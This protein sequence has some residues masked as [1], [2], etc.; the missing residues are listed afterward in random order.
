MNAADATP[1]AVLL[2]GVPFPLSWEQPPDHW[3]PVV[4]AAG[5]VGLVIEAGP[6]SDLFVSPDGTEPTLNAPRLLGLPDPQFQLR[7]LVNVEFGA[8]FD[9]GVLL[10]WGHQRSWAKLCLENSPAGQ[11]MVVS[12]VTRG[13]SDDANNVDVTGSSAWLRISSPS[14]GSYAFHAATDG[15]HWKLVRH[16][17]LDPGPDHVMRLGFVAQSPTGEGCRASFSQLRYLPEALDDLRNGE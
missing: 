15:V 10:L 12:V 17:H 5:E 9:A 11:P 6:Q 13:R 2:P 8:T 16:F 1:E 4:S 3:E 14:R 7:A